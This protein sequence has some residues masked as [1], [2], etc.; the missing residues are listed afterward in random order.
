LATAHKSAAVRFW[1]LRKQKTITTLN[2]EKSLLASVTSLAYDASGKYLAYG[3]KGGVQVTTVK[4]WGSTASL[5]SKSP[6]SGIVWG[7]SMIVTCGEKE[8]DVLFYGK[9]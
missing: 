2:P 5:S 8:R 3:G 4:E 7:E 1:D 6:V 9:A